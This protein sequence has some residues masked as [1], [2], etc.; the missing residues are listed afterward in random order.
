MTE[1]K[2]LNTVIIHKGNDS[3]RRKYK[4]IYWFIIG[5]K[6]ELTGELDSRSNIKGQ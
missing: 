1:N 3:E 2:I 6:I 4:C 5:N